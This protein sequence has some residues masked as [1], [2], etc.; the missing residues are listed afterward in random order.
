MNLTIRLKP[1]AVT[2][3][4]VLLFP[5]SI[6]HSQET[7]V[8]PGGEQVAQQQMLSD[9]EQQELIAA[10]SPCWDRSELPPGASR[11]SFV[12]SI[13]FER[14]ASI[15]DI[16]LASRHALE[17]DARVAFEAAQQ[18]IIQC[19][20]GISALSPL[21]SQ[22]GRQV[23]LRFS[24]TGIRFSPDLRA[25]AAI[26]IAHRDAEEAR[27]ITVP[28]SQRLYEREIQ[29]L[30]R[31]VGQCWNRSALHGGSAH[32]SI[33]TIIA[34]E[35]DESVASIELSST[36]VGENADANLAFQTARRAILRC[37]RN[38]NLPADRY[39][40]WRQI[41]LVFGPEGIDFVPYDHDPGATIVA[42]TI[43]PTEARER[44]LELATDPIDPLRETN[45]IPF[46]E[47]QHDRATLWCLEAQNAH[48]EDLTVA[49][50]Y[51]RALAA[52]NEEEAGLLIQELAG[53]GY[54]AAHYYMGNFFREGLNGFPRS[55]G[56]AIGHYEMALQL[57]MP[58]AASRLAR[59]FQQTG[60]LDRSRTLWA[61]AVAIGDPNA[62]ESL[63]ALDRE[64]SRR[65]AA[66]RRMAVAEEREREL[67]GRIPEGAPNAIVALN[68]TRRY[69][70][71]CQANAMSRCRWVCSEMSNAIADDLDLMISYPD[72]VM[73]PW[74]N[75]IN[76]IRVTLLG[77]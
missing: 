61:L 65:D 4:V 25:L 41:R 54:P 9:E 17:H 75:C 3:L 46:V 14:D 33:E 67:F 37:S 43:D 6:I 31:A 39:S 70:T 58:Q 50:N 13:T 77:R 45:G 60:Q 32:I 55:L 53:S 8:Q 24:T 16:G 69:A 23:Q 12:V 68:L 34:F 48:P 27:G 15:A 20:G 5:C 2:F 52:G 71:V 64:I 62:S 7:P 36:Y 1:H 76:E 63:D 57:G 22:D 21:R 26:A 30:T 11:T 56:D 72:Q 74:A 73:V 10:I 40:G 66:E 35:R 19:S 59:I 44:C 42:S 47:M 38:L 18:A 49:F 51:A 28:L 29:A